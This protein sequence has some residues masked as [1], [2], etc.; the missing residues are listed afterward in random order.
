MEATVKTT[1][2][3]QKIGFRDGAHEETA[4]HQADQRRG[5]DKAEPP[6]VQGK[7]RGRKTHGNADGTQDV[8]ITELAEHAAGD[9]F[10]VQGTQG[11]VFIRGGRLRAMDS[12]RH[13]V[14]LYIYMLMYY[15]L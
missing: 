11:G 13:R 12:L 9:D 2:V 15:P 14:P 3:V 7:G 8:T 4:D 1:I 5:A 10:F 6:G